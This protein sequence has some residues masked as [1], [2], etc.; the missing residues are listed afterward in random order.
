VTQ[1]FR[2]PNGGR[3]RRDRTLSFTFDGRPYTGCEGDTLASAL[4]ANDV[5]LVGR[6]FKY[7]RPRGIL[8]TGVEDPNALVTIDRSG[9]R[10]TPN[11]RATGVDLYDGLQAYSQNCWPSLRHDFGAI[12]DRLSP[13]LSTGFYYKTFMWP[14][15]LWRRLYE[16]IIRAAAG[17][18]RA[19]SEPD[20]DRYLHQFAHCDLLVIGGGPA[21]LAAALAAS[22]TGR[23]VILCD[24]QAEAGGSLLAEPDAVIEGKPATDWLAGTL[25][26]LRAAPNVTLL[27]RT[28]A[29]GW[30]PDNFLGLAE[31]CTD[32][33]AMPDPHL[34]RE[35]LWQ[36][37]TRE[38]VIA[39]G[40]IER[41]LVFP[42]NDRPGIMLADA[43]RTY[44]QRYGVQVGSYAVVVTS[45]DSAYR[46]ALA[47]HRAGVTI[48]AIAD[49][50][51]EAN[52]PYPAAARAAGI[53]VRTGTSVVGTTGRLRVNAVRLNNRVA[54]I[55]C[56]AVLMCGGWTP[57]VHLHSQSR[58]RLRFED[59]IGAFVP[60][61]I[62]ARGYSA[63]ACAGEFDLSRCLDAGYAA[64]ETA[65]RSRGS[66]RHFEVSGLLTCSPGTLGTDVE[67][68]DKAF[69]DLQND[70]TTKD[71]FIATSE[72]FRS[73]EHVK[74]Y[75]TA[76]MATDQGKTSNLNVLASVAGF[77]NQPVPSIGHT[78]F[79]MPYSPVTFGTLA[80][81][82]RGALL[83]PVRCAPLH[84]W[85][86][87]Q[88]AIF[89]MAGM[90]KR[91]R[92]F[93]RAGEDM[94]RAVAREC[95]AVR[96]S[97]GLLDASTLGKIEVVGP[98]AAEFLDRLYVRNISTM[99]PGRCRYAV[100][101]RETGFILDD[102]IVARLAQDRF[103]IT[104]TTGGAASVLHHMEDYLQTEFPELRVWLTSTTEHWA[105]IS[106]QGPRSR[107]MLTPLVE[108]MDLAAMPHMSV[109]DCRVGDVQA[110]MF[111]VSFT[112]ELGYEINIPS[113]HAPEIWHALL[114]SGARLGV[115]PYGTEA[116]HVLRAEC[117]FIIV[118]Q[119]TDGT[120]TPDDV[121]LGWMIGKDKRDFVGERSLQLAD[122]RRRDRRQLVGLRTLDSHI[123]LEEGTQL[124]AGGDRQ[125]LGHVT[126][127][128]WSE[129][130]Q[131]S[132]A[133]AL[134]S[135]GRA[136]IGSTLQA[137]STEAT[138]DV[139]V[140]DPS[141]RTLRPK[142]IA[143][144]AAPHAYRS[145]PS[146]D[147]AT[148]APCPEVTLTM[149][150]AV[151]RLSVRAGAAAATTLGRV[152][153]VLLGSVPG[154]AI[155]SRD[156]AAMWLGPDEWLVLAP[157][158]TGLAQ[159][160]DASVGGLL[161]SVVDISHHNAAIEVAGTH[162]TCCINAFNA[163]DLDL[164]VFPVDGCARTVFGKAEI[165]L[166]RTAT[167][168]F[169][170]EVARSFA[171]YVGAC[172]EEARQEF[173]G[174]TSP[175]RR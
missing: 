91:A 117:G 8:S 21:G 51:G 163:L 41:P 7:H 98:D 78:T 161:A 128:Y 118:G 171:P 148:T 49:R 59:T 158:D 155:T 114:A 45:D 34:P 3:I 108:G 162:A 60:D 87:A 110:R 4:L 101:L 102:G 88:G 13:L 139:A 112:G 97:V 6:S 64:G 52:G 134:L 167:Q 75:T 32:H 37:R 141:V 43:A 154:R 68:H 84:D 30:F 107:E 156:R 149:L 47:L 164:R 115:T 159:R 62:S 153:G 12:T 48:A 166:W 151:T 11:L 121:G 56:D 138:I 83:E 55:P 31:R 132:I 27:A 144:P 33:L 42:H 25:A 122:M 57:S 109:R 130:Q 72:G 169:R 174:E 170:I 137:I 74:R 65:A 93:P 92:C 54:A 82:A 19:P 95:R 76:G 17:L 81:A 70:V 123:V 94:Q 15:A 14:P 67:P 29:F 113:A 168:V 146:V 116:M 142:T 165:V 36:V 152:L 143:V 173:L 5:H 131:Q 20:P 53:T 38:V 1:V 119:E 129:P 127:A 124:V 69:V 61:T 40:A 89:E 85:A 77:V 150:P 111:R 86:V 2:T 16:P 22:A 96:E 80:G 99:A 50:R 18:G 126:S 66:T 120:V 103:H 44:L 23:R 145:L 140:V 73:I 133:L 175:R 58:G 104:T 90:W 105:V 39:A 9:R 100:M 157:V 24:E 35:R 106:V 28:T 147:H 172:L 71:L 125:S 160:A 63:G 26:T 135:N 46:A 136:R 79:R 10:V